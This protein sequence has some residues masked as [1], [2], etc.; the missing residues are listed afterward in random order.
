ML[1]HEGDREEGG[2]DCACCSNVEH[3]LLEFDGA[4]DRLFGIWQ[5]DIALGQRAGSVEQTHG[6]WLGTIFGSRS[7]N[8][9]AVK[10]Q[11]P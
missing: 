3:Q 10:V 2:Q 7:G 8:D 11:R 4:D 1:D 9:G 5:V 6:E